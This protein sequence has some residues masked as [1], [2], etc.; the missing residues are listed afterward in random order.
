MTAKDF[1]KKYGVNIDQINYARKKGLI[2]TYVKKEPN[3]V[4]YIA[5][6]KKHIRWAKQAKRKNEELSDQ[7][8]LFLKKANKLNYDSQSIITK[9]VLALG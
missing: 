2:E 8:K 6:T 7:E 1:C 3:R 5:E 4:M 9:E